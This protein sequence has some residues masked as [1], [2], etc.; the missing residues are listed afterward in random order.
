MRPAQTDIQSCLFPVVA[1]AL[2]SVP[3][4]ALVLS[5]TLPTGQ[6]LLALAQ[7]ALNGT[8][9]GQ[10]LSDLQRS[11][12][13]PP[14]AGPTPP[15]TAADL[16]SALGAAYG[17]APSP[18]PPKAAQPLNSGSS[19]VAPGTFMAVVVALLAAL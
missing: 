17:A 10:L 9:T 7:T 2:P 18:P 1:P 12:A 6:G 4:L 11:S 13:P 14:A 16:L 5:C 8:P 3:N 19:A 15:L